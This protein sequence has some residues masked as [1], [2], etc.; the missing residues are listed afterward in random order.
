M[1][2]AGTTSG[3]LE[4]DL[5]LTRRITEQVPPYCKKYIFKIFYH[6]LILNFLWSFGPRGKVKVLVPNLL[7]ASLLHSLHL[8]CPVSDLD[9]SRGAFAYLAFP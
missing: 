8:L 4:L 2:K 7:L 5:Y 3:D 9:P 1:L 6:L